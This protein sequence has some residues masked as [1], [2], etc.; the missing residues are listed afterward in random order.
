MSCLVSFAIPRFTNPILIGSSHHPQESKSIWADPIQSVLPKSKGCP[1]H[2]SF[3]THR[4]FL[5]F[6]EDTISQLMESAL[7]GTLQDEDLMSVFYEEPTE[8]IDSE[9]QKFINTF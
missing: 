8:Q 1:E 7:S 2:P 9:T 4:F 3:F 5:M 6:E